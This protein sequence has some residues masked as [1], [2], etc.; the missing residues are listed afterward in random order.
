MAQ[1]KIDIVA[2]AQGAV[3]ELDKLNSSLSKSSTTLSTARKNLIAEGNNITQNSKAWKEYSTV[4]QRVILGYKSVNS[5]GDAASKSLK[6][7]NSELGKL[8]SG[9]ASSSSVKL[10]GTNFA[11]QA[12]DASKA[13]SSVKKE[14]EKA[15]K[16]SE[17]YRMEMEAMLGNSLPK[18]KKQ[19]KDK[20]NALLSLIKAEKGSSDK[21]QILARDIQKLRTEIQ[22]STN[23]TTPF[24]TKITGLVKS[25]VSAQAILS[26]V[27]TAL[28]FVTNTI[29]DSAEAASEA[30]ETMNLFKETF[31][32][33][34]L[35]AISTAETLSEKFGT[36][37]STMQKALGTFGDLIKGYGGSDKQALEFAAQAAERTMDIISYKNIAGDTNEIYSS[38]AS[39][40]AGNVENFRKLGYVMTQAEVKMRLQKK[41]LDDLTG[42]ALQLAQV[43]ERLNILLEKSANAQGDLV[44]TMDSTANVNRRVSEAWKEYKEN[45]GEDVNKLFTPIKKFW[46]DYLE[47]QNKI[48]D[49]QKEFKKEASEIQQIYSLDNPDDMKSFELSFNNLYNSSDFKASLQSFIK[50][51]KLYGASL[52]DVYK[53]IDERTNTKG[54]FEN[55]SAMASLKQAV[56]AEWNRVEAV[57]EAKELEES[58][59][60]LLQ[61]E[62]QLSNSFIDNLASIKGISIS[63]LSISDNTVSSWAKTEKGTQSGL[64]YMNSQEM[65][66]VD[67]VIAQLDSGLEEFSSSIEVAL[68]K[69]T[70]SDM[71]SNKQS[72]VESAYETIFNEF[73]KNDSMISADEQEKLD[74]IIAIFENVQSEIQTISAEETR[75]NAFNSSLSGIN[76]QIATARSNANLESILSAISSGYLS[77]NENS[78]QT[79]LFNAD[80]LLSSAL[81]NAKTLSEKTEVYEAINSLKKLIN[82]KYDAEASR[83]TAEANTN[84]VDVLSELSA[85]ISK[86]SN[87][88]TASPIMARTTEGQSFS[89]EA[90]EKVQSYLD[91]ARASLEEIGMLTEENANTLAQSEKAAKD[92]IAAIVESIDMEAI[93]EQADALRNSLLDMFGESGMLYSAISGMGTASFDWV[94]ALIQLASQ[95]EVVQQLSS[96]ISDTIL[97]V[98]DS[99]LE[100]LTDVLMT[101]TETVGALLTTV[102]E[103]FYGLIVAISESLST[104]LTAV[105]TPIMEALDIILE[106]LEKM[107]DPI[108]V[109][110][111]TIVS[112]LEPIFSLLSPFVALMSSLNPILTLLNPIIMVIAEAF[113]YLGAGLTYVGAL[114]KIFAGNVVLFFT[115]MINGVINTLKSI[116]IFGWRPFGWMRTIDDSKYREWANLN[117]NEEMNKY[118]ANIE[119]STDKILDSSMG[120]EDNTSKDDKSE[121]IKQLQELYDSGLISLGT[122]TGKLS[123]LT[124]KK[125]DE[126]HYSNGGYYYQT[127]QGSYFA[128]GSV[129]INVS[130]EGK[131]AK[132]LA[133]EIY[134]MFQKMGTPGGSSY[135]VY[136]GLN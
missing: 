135:R 5:D 24:S 88:A 60:S 13:L 26:A 97:P 132:E 64:N 98:L 19:L 116:N 101:L 36:A 30:E 46:L 93:A 11:S 103:P 58:R 73:L 50:E 122:Y 91:S 32:D 12:E 47:T 111:T 34:E 18:L 27:R 104:A 1:I 31:K 16:A 45:L 126:T 48:T 7:I 25:F 67:S 23:A 87:T 15:K 63:P 76:S 102:L 100:P 89:D 52:E 53:L 80:E 121:L 22:S 28:N 43:Q 78:R 96:I 99:F 115:N 51:M 68:G 37:T 61:E 113:K 92:Q 128:K 112:L 42:S 4:L 6:T 75:V 71:L 127:S 8:I 106:P 133:S 105:L 9:G 57:R 124:G 130:G 3:Q 56:T 134:K 109:L 17:D 39:G 94:T 120:I 86:I 40:L 20:E 114:V 69:L 83:L 74:E 81:A 117:P 84:A 29:K 49:A 129:I 35:A 72:V 82:E 95:L 41:G 108:G 21:A 65:N 79:E 125:Y 2:Q 119:K 107:L 110:L 38:F 44:R 59:L 77:D 90:W 118:L 70:R 55:V 10:F 123:E 62:M 14:T 66:A 33:V 85:N 54:P 131:N 136:G